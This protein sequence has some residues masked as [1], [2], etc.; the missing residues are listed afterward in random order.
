M[1][2]PVFEGDG[3]ERTTS[4]H[5]GFRPPETPRFDGDGNEQGKVEGRVTF[6]P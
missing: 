1:K 5:G 4:Y 3:K 6:F 2:Q